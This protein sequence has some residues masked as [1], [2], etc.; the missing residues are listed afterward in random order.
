MYE[1][2]FGFS[3]AP[4]GIN[5]DPAFLYLNSNYR[6]AISLLQYGIREHK[7]IVTLI[8]EV[9]TGKTMLLN[10]L[11]ESMDQGAESVMIPTTQFTHDELI[12]YLLDKLKAPPSAFQ[13]KTRFN[14]LLE[15]LSSRNKADKPVV[16]LVD[17]A[18]DLDNGTLESIR[19]LSNFETPSRKLLQ[20]ILVGQ[21]ELRHKLNLPELRQLRQRVAI[22][23]TLQRLAA[24]ETP[25]YIAHRLQGAGYV[26][27]TTL[28][29]GD[30]LDLIGAYSQ[31]IPRLINA[32]CDNAL[33]IGFAGNKRWIDAPMI[34]EAANDLMLEP[35]E[36]DP[37]TESG[38]VSS[39]AAEVP[40]SHADGVWSADRHAGRWVVAIAILLLAM[41]I[42]YAGLR[43]D[44]AHWRQRLGEL[45]P[46]IMGWYGA[47]DFG[48]WPISKDDDGGDSNHDTG[49]H[50]SEVKDPAAALPS[51]HAPVEVE[52]TQPQSGAPGPSGSLS[53]MA[54][55]A[56]EA[57]EDA[58]D[59][60]KQS[61]SAIPP[62]E[63]SPVAPGVQ[64]SPVPDLSP[65]TKDPVT[66]GLEGGENDPSY[67]RSPARSGPAQTSRLVSPD[68]GSVKDSMMRQTGERDG[69]ASL[70]PGPA[71]SAPM[72]S[73]PATIAKAVETS[74]WNLV[75]KPGIVRTLQPGDTISSVARQVYGGAGLYELTAIKMANPEIRD[76]D[77]VDQGREVV[78]PELPSGLMIVRRDDG[79]ASVLLGASPSLVLA[80][81]LQRI[82]AEKG[83]SARIMPD[84]LS[85]S[86]KVYRLETSVPKDQPS[87]NAKMNELLTLR[88]MLAD[89][90]E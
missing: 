44:P 35:L 14:T 76:L 32:I 36:A 64:P 17:E 83:L 29:T 59:T 88:E 15:I 63:P 31:G 33:L 25:S 10:Q 16:V 28:F 27:G 3:K 24:S 51:L 7:G 62:A 72:L 71:G 60:G 81:R 75:K 4:F 23:F 40:P 53:D 77:F 2:H 84:K 86:L 6:E 8:G 41:G 13:G 78:I 30:A 43:L 9:G 49:P 22:S 70:D 46:S 69:D 12:D 58:P 79:S 65:G 73:S 55:T 5:P 61:D 45:A 89:Y 74:P 90:E 26:H 54:T 47:S 11:L 42:G 57:Y 38:E 85:Q 48:A 1:S 56:N 39:V 19:L 37:A 18:Q 34:R 20:I 87:V 82:S 67:Q 68:G 52:R 80:Q 50:A 66:S 21:P